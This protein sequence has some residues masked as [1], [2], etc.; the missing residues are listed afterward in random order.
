MKNRIIYL[1]ILLVTIFNG[2]KS[3]SQLENKSLNKIGLQE[4]VTNCSKASFMGSTLYLKK[5]DF[6]LTINDKIQ[7]ASGT[8][9]IHTDSFIVIS[10]Q[11]LLGIE[12]AR[13][14]ITPT[15][16]VVLDR[17]HKQVINY[18]LV[19]FAENFAG[20]TFKNFQSLLCNQIFN[21]EGGSSSLF[22]D[23]SFKVSYLT[24]GYGI[25]S[26][27]DKRFLWVQSTELP[28]FLQQY[29]VHPTDYSL[30]KI[31]ISKNDLS[32]SIAV[33]YS[34]FMDLDGFKYPLL[35]EGSGLS[36]ND[37]FKFS[38]KS[39][40]AQVNSSNSLNFSIPDDYEKVVR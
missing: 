38:I 21:I 2:C 22:P 29:L 37:A 27:E 4:L 31:I 35:M 3:K 18:G 14:R 30:L 10:I 32:R 26:V 39:G 7:N 25:S 23:D 6:N 19:K 34:S 33:N 17:F 13:L 1:A 36:A 28:G 20:L 11:A 40:S 24:D 16:V 5:C 15:E 9:Y 12:V 8:I